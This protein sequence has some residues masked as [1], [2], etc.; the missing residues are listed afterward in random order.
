M[1]KSCEQNVQI[2]S[3]QM[4]L[5]FC[6]Y[7]VQSVLYFPSASYVTLLVTSARLKSELVIAIV[8]VRL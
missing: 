5:K 8:T 1:W 4:L 7:R 6:E 2:S 3:V